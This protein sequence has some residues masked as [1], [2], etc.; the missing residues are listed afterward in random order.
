MKQEEQNVDPI[1]KTTDENGNTHTF[2]LIEIIEV[3]KK[4]YGL[5]EYLDPE[6]PNKTF[7]TK[8]EEAELIVMRIKS[9]QGE[10]VFEVIEDEN[11]FEQVMEYIDLHEDELHFE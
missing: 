1:I 5:F 2:K 11:E 7:K 4:E 6:K 3:K 9:K 8:D 10:S